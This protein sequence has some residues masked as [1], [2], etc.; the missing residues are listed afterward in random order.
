MKI[1]IIFATPDQTL[2]TFIGLRKQRVIPSSAIENRY[3][4]QNRPIFIVGTLDI[5]GLTTVADFTSRVHALSDDL[6]GFILLIDSTRAHLADGVRDAIFTMEFEN[7]YLGKSPQNRVGAIITPALKH[8]TFLAQRFD[9]GKFQKILLLPFDSF[10]A[11]ELDQV[12]VLV[13]R[14]LT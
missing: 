2:R 1:G 13:T 8:Y 5:S 14:T 12:R 9:D 10:I 11:K 7:Q 4:E 3:F 6:D